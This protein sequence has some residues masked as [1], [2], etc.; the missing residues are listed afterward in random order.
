MCV[1]M[2]TAVDH[3]QTVDRTCGAFVIHL[4]MDVVTGKRCTKVDRSR[5][6]YRLGSQFGPGCGDMK[7]AHAFPLDLVVLKPR[8]ICEREVND[9]VSQIYAV[10]VGTRIA[11]DYRGRAV[12]FGDDHHA[13]KRRRR[14]GLSGAFTNEQQMDRRCDANSAR[15]LEKQAAGKQS[16]VERRKSIG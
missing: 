9:S 15:Y 10:V 11:L 2:L 5:M 13:G 14:S 1:G 3:V 8:A 16:S 7:R 12:L 6:I 4:H